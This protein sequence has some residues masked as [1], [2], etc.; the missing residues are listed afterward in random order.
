MVCLGNIC[1]S[2]IAEGV[3]QHL[4]NKH[5]LNWT[6]ESAGTNQFHIGE[7]P[8]KSSQKVC[9]ENGIDISYQRARRFKKE[10]FPITEKLCATVLSLPMHT[11]MEEEMLIYITDNVLELLK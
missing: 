2:P 7:A 4:A 9:K 8:H 3:L 6:I 1:R 5:N 10:D 11:E